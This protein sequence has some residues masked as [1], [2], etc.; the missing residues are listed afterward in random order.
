MIRAL[1]SFAQPSNTPGITRLFLTLLLTAVAGTAAARDVYS[2]SFERTDFT[3]GLPLAGQDGWIAPPPF[4]PNAARISTG[5]PRQGKQTLEIPGSALVSQAFINEATGGYYD[6]IGSYRR[7]VDYD[8]QGTQTLVVSAHVR[9]DGARTATNFF[10]TSIAAIGLDDAG[11]ASGVG[12]LAISSDGHVYGYSSQD[13]VPTFL[14]STRVTLN[15]WHDLAIHVDFA[16][17]TYS[18]Y[19]DCEWLGTFAFDPSATSTVLARGSIIA[20][21]APDTATLHKA[22]Y[23]AHVD[24]FSIK[25]VGQKGGH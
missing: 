9:V 10:S 20:Y 14:T 16:H 6:A 18:F 17:R 2:T 8:S 13:L 24:K 15:Q 1:P 25:A 23:S 11:D 21:A 7:A 19:V 3:A 22:D 5:K 4:S 12:E